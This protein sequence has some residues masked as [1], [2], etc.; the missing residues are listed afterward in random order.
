[1]NIAMEQ[2]EGNVNGQL[3]NKYGDAF[4]CR[5][6]GNLK[7]WLVILMLLFKFLFLVYTIL[8]WYN[9]DWDISF[10]AILFISI[11]RSLADETYFLNFY[12]VM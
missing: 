11:L 7:N 1:M 2:T 3:N 12:Q 4:I 8:Y 5:N 6:D 9:N 10:D